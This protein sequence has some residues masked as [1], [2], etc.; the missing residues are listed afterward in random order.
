MIL[1]IV[2]H[3][4][5][6][7]ATDTLLDAGWDQARKAANRL[8]Q[9]GVDEIH[10]SPMGRA[11]QTAQPLAEALRLPI[12]IEPWAFELGD[13]SRTTY[14]DGEL[15]GISSLD[16]VLLHA[17]EWRALGIEESFGRVEALQGAEFEKRY[18]S[19]ADGLDGMLSKFGYPRDQD[20]FYRVE[21]PNGK[22]IALFCHCAMQRVLMSHMLHIPYQLLGAT[23]QNN[24]TG[25]TVLYFDE[26]GD[27]ERT[28][29]LLISYGDVGHLYEGGPLYH[30]NEDVP[31]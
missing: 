6:D 20:G 8:V 17:P 31:F 19:I 18:H 28:V 22:H 12:I 2:R 24:F 3:G 13:E 25:I 29:P 14:P 15:K 23:L 9:S 30:Y 27:K 1:Y 10:A 5:P 26:T 21:K 4:Q 16:A 11:I 7:Y